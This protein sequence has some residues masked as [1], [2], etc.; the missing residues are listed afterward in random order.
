MLST[1]SYFDSSHYQLGSALFNDQISDKFFQI[2]KS[3]LLF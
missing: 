1:E 3:A 2:T